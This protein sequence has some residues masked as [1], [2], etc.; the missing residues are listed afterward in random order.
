MLNP[1]NCQYYCVFSLAHMYAVT[2]KLFQVTYEVLCNICQIYS[3]LNANKCL[4]K[5]FKIIFARI[6]FRGFIFQ[7]CMHLDFLKYFIFIYVYDCLACMSYVYHQYA[8]YL[9]IPEEGLKFLGTGIT[10]SCDL[11]CQCCKPNLCSLHEP[12]FQ[13]PY[14]RLLIY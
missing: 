3:L 14:K 7:D 8:W 2:T 10:D 12:F 11:P 1:C 6:L 5:N 4:L 9:R 13:M